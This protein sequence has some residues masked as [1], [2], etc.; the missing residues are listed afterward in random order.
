MDVLPSGTGIALSSATPA[1]QNTL[2]LTTLSN[3][4]GL[5]PSLGTQTISSATSLAS[6][7]DGPMACYRYGALTVNAA[8]TVTNRCRGLVLLCDSLSVGAAGSIS[9]TARGAAGSSKWAN[10]DIGIPTSML[11]SAKNTSWTTFLA[12]LQSN[13]YCIF[14]PTLFACPPPGMGDVIADYANWAARMAAIV[15]AAGC[16]AGA[17]KT[18]TGTGT[19]GLAGTNAPGGGGTG[20]SN[21]YAATS[22]PGTVWGGGPG[23]GGCGSYMATTKGFAPDQYGGVGGIGGPAGATYNSGGGA[24]NP[25]GAGYLGGT[26][27]GAAG[28]AGTGGVLIIIVRG[29]VTLTT[30]HALTAGGTAG[31]AASGNTTNCGGGGSGGGFVGLYYG[32]A[33]TGTPN[34]TASGGSGGTSSNSGGPGGAGTALSAPFSAMGWV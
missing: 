20:G 1:W 13:N 33:L 16:G 25:G 8:L 2:K 3:L 30:G 28:S 23:S 22:A 24:G 4:F 17:N 14:D 19:T 9:M 26:G 18:N 32:G 7:L 12:W 6:T 34:L 21:G 15:S 29:D 31:G 10:Q 11:L 5:Y 27:V